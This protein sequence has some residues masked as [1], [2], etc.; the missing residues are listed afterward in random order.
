LRYHFQLQFSLFFSVTVTSNRLRYLIVLPMLL[1]LATGCHRKQTDPGRRTSDSTLPVTPAPLT[2]SVRLL[3]TDSS[4]ADS[5]HPFRSR[6]TVHAVIHT[7]NASDTSTVSGTW[8]Y[9]TKHTMIAHNEAKL[10][11]GTNDTHFDLINANPWPSG[12]YS[13]IV[14]VDR[15]LHDTVLF[16]IEPKRR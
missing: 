13:L 4:T 14:D 7:E 5:A 11:T 12:Q 3:H 6:D 16:E 15:T 2:L 8:L 9:L 10:A 1:L